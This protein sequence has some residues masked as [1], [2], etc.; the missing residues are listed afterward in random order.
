[1]SHLGIASFVT[2]HWLNLSFIQIFTKQIFIF[3]TGMTHWQLDATY[4]HT[5]IKE[6]RVGLI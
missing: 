2:S 3:D 6:I 4:M 1:M 5:H